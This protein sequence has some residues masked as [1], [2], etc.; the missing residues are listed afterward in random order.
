[1]KILSQLIWAS[2][3]RTF[4]CSSNSFRYCWIASSICI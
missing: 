1:M 3:R 4:Q 2:I